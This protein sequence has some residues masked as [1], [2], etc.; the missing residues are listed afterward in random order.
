M[1]KNYLLV[2]FRQIK[3][4]KFFSFVN[5]FCLT[6]GM[7]AA[8]LILIYISHELSY[9]RFHENADDVYRVQM[10][11]YVGG[12]LK[13]EAARTYPAM[14]P[15]LIKDMPEI[16]AF[17]RLL[18]D[19]GILRYEEQKYLEDQIY[20][21]DADFFKIFSFPLTRGNEATA[22]NEPGSMVITESAAK[23]YFPGGLDPMDKTVYFNK[24]NGRQESYRITGI[25]AD[26]P[27]NSHLEFDFLLSYKTLSQRYGAPAEQSWQ[28]DNYYTYLLLDDKVSPASLESRFQD[29]MNLYKG[30]LFMARDVNEIL[31]LQP[32]TDIHLHS[33]LKFE[34]SINSDIQNLYFLAAIAAFILI[35][36]WINYVTLS[37]SKAIQRAKEVGVK[38]I[39]GATRGGLIMQFLVEFI[40]MYVISTVVS[41]VLVK[42]LIPYFN[43]L[44][45]K[46]LSLEMV[47]GTPNFWLY[48]AAAFIGGILL[49]GIYPAIIISSFKPVQ[50]LREGF[51]NLP[52][53]VSVQKILVT[54]QIV[55]S[56]AFIIGTLT[57]YNQL[58]YML[59]F[60]LGFDREHVL[61]VKSPSVFGDGQNYESSS[62]LFKQQAQDLQGVNSIT[63]SGFV[64]GLN[65]RWTAGTVRRANS[66]PDETNTYYVMAVDYGF[67]DTYDMEL[68]AGRNFSKEFSDTEASILVNERASKLLGYAN[69]EDAIGQPILFGP[70]P[71]SRSVIVGVTNNYHHL[72]LKNDQQP[73]IMLFREATREYYSIKL[74]GQNL[75][76][77][78]S[79]IQSRWDN[80]F[81][82]N[83]FDF[84]FLDSFY[85]RQYAA[86]RQ[87][88]DLFQVFSVVAIILASLGLFALAAFTTV[89]RKKE[90]GIRK[91]VGAGEGSILMLL[92]KDFMKLVLI[93]SVLISPIMYFAMNNWLDGYHYRTTLGVDIFLISTAIV[94]I[95]TLVVISYHTLKAAFSNP[96]KSLRGK[97]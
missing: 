38:K 26:L 43:T 87:L 51:A 45:G 63:E 83:P 57:V 65:I 8:V 73:Q 27:D 37:T 25:M 5:L 80:I 69:P 79:E 89:K 94:T 86:D 77:T 72:S 20:F 1:V 66:S 46:T 84:Y 93:A 64:P 92:G 67:L 59:N 10:D 11:R 82:A 91:V 7:T 28:V 3:K 30:D 50:A 39:H 15:N 85:D 29:F 13:Y 78:I 74:S 52:G 36:A 76:G 56:I 14:G 61:I 40:M 49:S 42:L 34:V 44:S 17:V 23:R 60:N 88:I 53:R 33:D 22:L 12:E 90:I 9:D 47:L 24:D 4:D 54:L 68:L 19:D 32:I 71:D 70:T 97:A 96:V 21:A 35:T 48:F 41:F 55:V 31:S 81:T 6:V 62:V 2:A 16:E 18:P 75:Q 58:D 95:I